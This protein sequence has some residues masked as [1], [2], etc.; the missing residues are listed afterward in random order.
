MSAAAAWWQRRQYGSSGSS[1][2]AW[3]RVGNAATIWRRWQQ[4][5]GGNS[6]GRMAVVEAARRQWR[7][8]R[9][10]ISGIYAAGSATAVWQRCQ[11]QLAG[12]AVAVVAGSA[13]AAQGRR[14]WP[15]QPPPP[16]CC[17]CAL[18]LRVNCHLCHGVSRT[19]IE[20]HL[21]LVLGGGGLEVGS[22]K[23]DVFAAF[24]RNFFLH[25]H[26][27]Q[28]DPTLEISNP[29]GGKKGQKSPIFFQLG[30]FLS[31]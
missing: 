23:S 31:A 2:A 5:A 15:W 19:L 11:R 18:L 6:D 8:Q 10:V 12:S 27:R 17:H 1:G 4:R 16:P 7:R 21:F 20:K 9:S 14:A 3:Q 30:S 26:G 13:L 22:F 29:F 25:A 24:P 28:Q